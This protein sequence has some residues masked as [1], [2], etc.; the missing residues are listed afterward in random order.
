NSNGADMIQDERTLVYT[1]RDRY[2][3]EDALTF[4]VTDG[5]GPDDP[6]GRKATLTLPITV[7]PPDNQPPVFTNGAMSV[8]PGEAAVTLDLAPMTSDPDPDDKGK[9][10]F[11]LTGSMPAGFK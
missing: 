2:F 5:T 7:L 10:K 9:H 3:G 1:S 11:A 8:A 6:E 4:E